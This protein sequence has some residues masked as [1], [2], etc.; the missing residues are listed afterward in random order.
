LL[1][2][3]GCRE[4]Q[5][6]LVLLPARFLGP[7]FVLTQLAGVAAGAQFTSSDPPGSAQ[8]R[9]VSINSGRDL[10]GYFM[11]ASGNYHGF[12][13]LA[14]GTITTFDYAPKQGC[15]TFATGINAA[16]Q[17]VG[18]YY[19][20]N[21]IQYDFLRE[22]DGSITTIDLNTPATPIPG[23]TALSGI[24]ASGTVAGTYYLNGGAT[25]FVRTHDGTITTFQVPGAY[26]TVPTSINNAADT[27]GYFNGPTGQPGF[28]RT[29]EGTFQ[30]FGVQGQA[31]LDQ[32]VALNDAGTAVV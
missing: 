7:V 29:A 2:L 20:P 31:W 12:L 1:V 17:I 15:C 27:A 14:N 32:P 28:I 22:P 25:G 19:G 8:T 13:R 16:D 10:A 4:S 23:Q 5:I 6:S 30:T 26:A 3:E 9:P 18:N 11:D 24:N 21:N